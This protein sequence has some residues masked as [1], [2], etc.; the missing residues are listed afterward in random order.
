MNVLDYNF[1]KPEKGDSGLVSANALEHNIDLVVAH[2]HNGTN[3]EKIAPNA[4]DRQSDSIRAVDWVANPT[5]EGYK[6]TVSISNDAQIAGVSMATSEPAFYISIGTNKYKRIYP[7]LQNISLTTYDLIVNDS[8][9]EL[10]VLY[11]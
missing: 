10:E 3:S 2:N 6:Q 8:S 1:R 5:G 7:D 4:L 11:L 9:L